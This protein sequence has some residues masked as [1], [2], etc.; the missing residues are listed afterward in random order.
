[1]MQHLHRERFRRNG[2][3]V[4]TGIA[5]AL[6]SLWLGDSSSA[7]KAVY[8]GL[9]SVACLALVMASF[10]GNF[11]QRLL[12]LIPSAAACTLLALAGPAYF[13]L[14]V[15]LVVILIAGLNRRVT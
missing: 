8:V 3:F 6:L 13:E 9:M 5:C 14:G 10:R 15:T 1:M 12:L 7:S 2:P 4:L 11:G